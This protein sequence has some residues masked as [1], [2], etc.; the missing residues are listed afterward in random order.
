MSTT[1]E[2]KGGSREDRLWESALVQL[3]D[4][5]LMG[6]DQ[7]A[8]VV[9]RHHQ[10]EEVEKARSRKM[11]IIELAGYLGAALTIG[12]VVAIS[13]Q[14]WGDFSE[15]VQILVLA[16]LAAAVLTAAALIAGFAPGGPSTLLDPQQ[17]T[18]RRLVAVLGTAG[19][20]LTAGTMA[21]AY[22][23]SLSA[24]RAE[25]WYWTA[26]LAALVIASVV[27]RFAPG[28]VPTLGVGGALGATVLL[29]MLALGWASAQWATPLAVMCVAALAALVL[30]RWLK[31]VALVEAAAVAAWLM[32]AIPML[33][34]EAGWGVS[35]DE[36]SMMLW[37]GR[38]GI[39][40]LI[41]S[42][43]VEF[44]RGGNWPWAI[45]VAVGTAAFVGI[46]FGQA[47]GGA[48]GMTLAGVVLI[49]VA[50]LMLRAH[51]HREPPAP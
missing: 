16:A 7:V 11:A 24:A 48:I 18:R 44:A 51:R 29:G 3:T 21:L 9:E 49:V 15:F 30:V 4:E 37:T 20:G 34:A 28:V 35:A 36:A 25:N 23:Q 22:S 32:A 5:G 41:A 42:G 39:M 26:A 50:V 8:A 31:P 17:A 6:T 14:V 46:T 40:A 43:A 10:I 38:I 33:S 45:G 12:G 47:L 27:S 13:S 1:L 2:A 19:A